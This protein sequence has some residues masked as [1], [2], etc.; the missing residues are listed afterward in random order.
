MMIAFHPKYVF[1]SKLA[2]FCVGS[3]NSPHNQISSSYRMLEQKF[4]DEGLFETDYWYY[5][6]EYAKFIG[7]WLGMVT[8][9]VWNQSNWSIVA[10]CLCATSLWHQA[11]FVVHDGALSNKRGIV[12]SLTMPRKTFFWVLV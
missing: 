5:Y 2:R 6:R 12:K 9:I 7:L 3:F 8:F 4:Q 11:A 10:S 1:G